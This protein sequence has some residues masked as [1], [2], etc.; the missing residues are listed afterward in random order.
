[1]KYTEIQN[2]LKTLGIFSHNDIQLLSPNFRGPTLTEWIEKGWIKRIRRG[3]YIDSSFKPHDYDYFYIA[4][5]IYTPS[6]ISLESAL[7]HYGFIP[8]AVMQ[9]TSVTTRKTNLFS[10]EFG[11]YTYKTIKPEIYF[12]YK[13]FEFSTKSVIMATPEKTLLDYLYFHN[14]IVDVKDFEELRFNKDTINEN[15]NFKRLNRYIKNFKNKE[16]AKRFN[17]LKEYLDA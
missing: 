8:E 15:V 3:W 7:N 10:T 11:E 1:M 5:K 2:N 9:I 6:Y 4:N 12:G 13:I 14:E 16:L 17:I